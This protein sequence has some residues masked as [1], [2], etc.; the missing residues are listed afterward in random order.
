MDW[1]FFCTIA[2][3]VSKDRID[4]ANGASLKCMFVCDVCLFVC[5]FCIFYI[6]VEHTETPPNSQAKGILKYSYLCNN[7][8]NNNNIIATVIEIEKL[9]IEESTECSQGMHIKIAGY[10][11]PFCFYF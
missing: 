11:P 3:Q 4:L 1:I 6:L 8:N 2:E 9:R 5:Y 10:R 7:N